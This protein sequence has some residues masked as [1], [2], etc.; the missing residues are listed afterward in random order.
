MTNFKPGIYLEVKKGVIGTGSTAKDV[1]YRN[2]WIT[3]A[4]D[5]DLVSLLHLNDNFSPTGASNTILPSELQKGRFTY[6]PEE[7]ERFKAILK[8]MRDKSNREKAQ[9]QKDRARKA[10]QSSKAKWWESEPKDIKPGDIFKREDP[11]QP[12]A[13]SDGDDPENL[14]KLRYSYKKGPE[15]SEMQPKDIFQRQPSGTGANKP[16]STRPRPSRQ[17]K[18]TVILKRNNWWQT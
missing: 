7:N 5:K 9:A 10:S 2:L 15:P 13:E 18:T 12:K 8:R 4:W 3:A 1:E 14:F 16:L 11:T 6:L 17:K